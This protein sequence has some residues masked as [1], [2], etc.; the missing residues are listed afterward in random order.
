MKKEKLISVALYE[1]FQVLVTEDIRVPLG[2]LKFAHR[3]LVVPVPCFVLSVS[4]RWEGSLKCRGKS[5]LSEF[6]T[7]VRRQ[8]F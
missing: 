5:K 3:F 7:V 4:E 8:Y 6:C 1:D 2:H